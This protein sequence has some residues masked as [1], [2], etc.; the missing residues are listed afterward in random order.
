MEEFSF[1]R[2]PVDGDRFSKTY[3]YSPE[4]VSA[5][6][7][8]QSPQKDW[9]MNVSLAERVLDIS[10]NH[11][12]KEFT[13]EMMETAQRIFGKPQYKEALDYISNPNRN[14]TSLDNLNHSL[15]KAMWIRIFD[16][17]YNDR[18]H[19]IIT[20]EGQF[21][22]YARRKDG[23]KKLTG[24]GSNKEISSAVEALGLKGEQSLQQ[25]F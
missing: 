17:T 3:N 25:I 22:D 6:I 7:A 13:P 23:T 21:L 18:G 10:R 4:I 20:P 14:S 24:W 19:R 11:G 1:Y 2:K 9:Y 5:V 15:H 12:D 8:A 16:E